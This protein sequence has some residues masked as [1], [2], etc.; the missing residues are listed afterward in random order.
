M[1]AL[2]HLYVPEKL[3]NLFFFSF[4]YIHVIQE[5]YVR[6]SNALKIRCFRPKSNVHTYKTYAYLLGMLLLRS[7]DRS[8]RVY[9]AMLC[10]GFRGEFWMLDHFQ[11]RKSDLIFGGVI[12]LF[13]LGIGF[14]QWEIIL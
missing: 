2:R 13:V 3:V 8:C 4:R 10:R 11:I 1:H 14:S 9:Q 12:V 6:L 5:E 7:Y